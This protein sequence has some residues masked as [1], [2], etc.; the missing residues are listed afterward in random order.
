MRIT[1]RVFVVTGSGNGMG[2]EVAVELGRRGAHVAA[3]DIDR[4]GLAGTA[5]LVRT[6]G[7]RI[8]THV[9]DVTDDNAVAALPAAV[10]DAHGQV[11]GLVNIAGIA[12]RF[13]LFSDLG[14]EALDRVPVVNFTGTVRMCRAFLPILPILLARPEANI[15]N[16]SSL[17]ALVPF[18]SQLLY[19]A[20][21]AA[22]KQFSEGLDA[23][24]V[25]TDVRVVTV[26]P[27]NVATELAKNSGVEMLDAGSRRVY[28]TSP[29]AA[30]RKIVAGIARDRYR[31]IIGADAHVLHA[32]ARIAPRRTAR[33]VARQITS[34]LRE[35]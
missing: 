25:G 5:E 24:L 34:V 31:V 13:A 21:K 3:V 29:E 7:A 12:Q 14:A 27:G 8:T 17:S 33:L 1:D 32:L 23:E 22:V 20:S 9:V 6:T 35:Q 11:D 4:E 10:L 16:M 18:A 15:T 26:F 2:R 30:G 19:S 28:A